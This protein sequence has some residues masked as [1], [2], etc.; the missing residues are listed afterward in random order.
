MRQFHFSTFYN[1]FSTLNQPLLFILKKIL[2]SFTTIFS[3]FVLVFSKTLIPFF[4]NFLKSSFVSFDNI[5]Q[6][7]LLIFLYMRKKKKK[8]IFRIAHLLKICFIRESKN[9]L[10][11]LYLISSFYTL[12][13]FEFLPPCLSSFLKLLYFSSFSSDVL[14]LQR[15]NEYHAIGLT[16]GLSFFAC[17]AFLHLLAQA[18]SLEN[19]TAPRSS[20]LRSELSRSSQG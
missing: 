8:E 16:I 2:I 5:Q 14:Q 7:N 18:I 12:Q 3:L 13:N 4:E 20:L 1:I 9:A 17:L 15:L 11:L 6:I 10:R 19:L